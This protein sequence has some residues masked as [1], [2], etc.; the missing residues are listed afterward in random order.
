MNLYSEGPNNK[1]FP[2][3][4]GR[5]KGDQVL[6]LLSVFFILKSNR[7][8]GNFPSR[9]LDRVDQIRDKVN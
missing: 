4:S 3:K 7:V 2:V 6:S 9:V 1:E 5:E 8:F